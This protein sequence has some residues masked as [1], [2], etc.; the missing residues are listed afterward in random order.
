MC[1]CV[2][3]YI[4]RGRSGTTLRYANARGR[5]KRVCRKSS[6]RGSNEYSHGLGFRAFVACSTC[7]NCSGCIKTCAL[8]ILSLLL[9][10]HRPLRD[11]ALD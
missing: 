6:G 3:I 4:Y 7:S 1:V 10:M 9:V 2:Y 5:R 8:S 11:G